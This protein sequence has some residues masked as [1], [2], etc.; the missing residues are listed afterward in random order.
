MAVLTIQERAAQLGKW[1]GLRGLG[2]PDKRSSEYPSPAG[3]RS[4]VQNLC[5]FW[6]GLWAW[7]L[8]AATE[9]LG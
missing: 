7:S 1:P 3:P 9:A 8:D 4:V 2:G 5:W 6:R